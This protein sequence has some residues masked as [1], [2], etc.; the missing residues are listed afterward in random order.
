[1]LIR[2]EQCGRGN[3][4]YSKIAWIGLDIGQRRDFSAIA[5]VERWERMRAYQTPEFD[6]AMVRWVERMRLGTSYA[7]VV[8]RVREVT[9]LDALRGRCGIVVDATG[10]GAPVVE[11]LRRAGLGCEITAV[12]ITGGD[13]ETPRT[14]GGGPNWTVPKQDLIAGLQMLLEK[15]EL[16]I[17]R[18]LRD[19][20]AL[21]RELMD[22]R[23]TTR[24]NGRVRLGAEGHGEHDDLALALALGC[25]A[26][27]RRRLR[28][29][30][31][32]PKRVVR[33]VEDYDPVLKYH[34]R[35]K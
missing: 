11:M 1:M 17:A 4:A 23:A 26:V 19:G 15:K 27:T 31:E 22:V 30:T 7:A 20:M 32:P 18:G 14:A 33:S 6:C 8:E 34:C 16:R 2:Q 3:G 13:R 25:W 5:V 10:V 24:D 29:P 35:L 9:Q 28:V 21:R 12:T